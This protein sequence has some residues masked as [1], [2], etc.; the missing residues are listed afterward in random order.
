VEHVWS[1]ETTFDSSL[2]VLVAFQAPCC[3]C[4]PLQCSWPKPQNRLLKGAEW[5]RCRQPRCPIRFYRKL[6]FRCHRGFNPTR[7]VP[8]MAMTSIKG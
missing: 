2:G 6:I 8:C 3:G 1:P 4:R 5:I 7:A